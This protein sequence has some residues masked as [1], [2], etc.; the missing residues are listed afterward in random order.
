[1]FTLLAL[2]QKQFS[3][4]RCFYRL[5][6]SFRY[7]KQNTSLVCSF[8]QWNNGKLYRCIK[9]MYNSVKV[10]GWWCCSV[11]RNG[12]WFTDTVEPFAKCVLLPS[13]KSNMSKSNIVVFRKGGYLGARER[14]TYD[15]VLPVVNVYEYLGVRHETD[16]YSIMLWSY[17]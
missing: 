8:E 16:F 9:S 12:Y 13:V 4:N 3:L 7:Y 10:I 1:M 14:W 2:V 11:V 5:W 17:K 6:E 15:F